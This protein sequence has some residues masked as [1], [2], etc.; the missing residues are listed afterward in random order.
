MIM[1]TKNS[2]DT[3]GNQTRDVPACSALPQPTSPPL[4]PDIKLYSK[5]LKSDHFTHMSFR[6]ET[7]LSVLIYIM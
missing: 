1:S 5:Q 4:A 3:V 6:Q 7:F 2:N